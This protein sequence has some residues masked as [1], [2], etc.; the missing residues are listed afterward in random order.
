MMLEKG[1]L[2][3]GGNP[4]DVEKTAAITTEHKRLA[5]SFRG[6]IYA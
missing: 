2:P 4:L 3:G 1:L 5:L 6:I